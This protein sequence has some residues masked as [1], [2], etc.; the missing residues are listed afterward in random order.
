MQRH[1]DQAEA[2]RPMTDRPDLADLGLGPRGDGGRRSRRAGAETDGRRLRRAINR[3]AVVDALLDLYQ[4]GNLRPGT[5]EIAERAGIS[6]RS[7]FRYFEDTDDLAGEAITRQL[8]RALPLVQLDVGA[9]APFDDRVRRPGRPAV[10][11]SSTPSGQAARVSRLRAPFQPR[12]AETL[13]DSRRFLRGQLRTLFA[14]ELEA[15]GDERAEWALAAADVL[16]SFESY[17]LLTTDQGL[18][19]DEA[20]AVVGQALDRPAPPGGPDDRPTR[21][22]APRHPSRLPAGHRLGRRR[23]ARAAARVVGGRRVLHRRG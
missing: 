16:A 4:E 1:V 10:P 18:T 5:D 8:A 15:M 6:P 2:A 14:P 3:E 20:D 22:H 19:A 9:D 13:A 23:C 12:L 17:Q 11:A 7:L 21:Q